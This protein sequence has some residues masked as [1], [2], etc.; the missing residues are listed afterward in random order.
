MPDADLFKAISSGKAEVVTDLV[1]TFTADGVRL[2]SGRELKADIVVSATGLQLLMAGG[3]ELSVEGRV[4]ESGRLVSYKGVMY[5]GVP[6]LA[7]TFGDTNASWTLKADLTREHVCRLLGHMRSHGLKVCTP[8]PAAAGSMLPMT[9][10]S[11][12]HFK[13]AADL[14]PKQG[15]REP[16]NLHTNYLR[17]L[18]RLRFGR[19]DDG[20]LRFA[21]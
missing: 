5:G 21:A 15:S 3:A 2:T 19:V 20:V 1:E 12:G 4:L 16:F 17:D 10:F 14:L 18:L 6:N 13:R 11:S 9:D 7:A 8:D